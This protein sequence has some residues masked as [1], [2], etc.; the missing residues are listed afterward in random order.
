MSLLLFLFLG[1]LAE[2]RCTYLTGKY[3]AIKD[4]TFESILGEYDRKI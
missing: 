2:I 4:P 3:F 1:Q